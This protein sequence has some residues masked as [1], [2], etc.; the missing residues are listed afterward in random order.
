MRI[1]NCCW[2]ILLCEL[3][4][5]CRSNHTNNI[6]TFNELNEH[7]VI[8]KKELLK[9]F[10]F[11]WTSKVPTGLTAFDVRYPDSIVKCGKSLHLSIIY[12]PKELFEIEKLFVPIAKEKVLYQDSC[13]L[14]ISKFNN[15]Y[16]KKSYDSLSYYLT[17]HCNKLGPPIPNFVDDFKA[18]E[19]QIGQKNIGNDLM[20][21]IIDSKAG[22][23]LEKKYLTE[24]LGLTTEWRNGYSRGVAISHKYN[25]IIYWVNEW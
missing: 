14:I 22:E 17:T 4:C 9:H 5:F 19:M 6:V 10:P 13:H 11:E 8:F 2:I 24:G 12:S 25:Y 1:I 7:K 16:D 20:V 18:L 15:F 23:F 3:F 21:Y